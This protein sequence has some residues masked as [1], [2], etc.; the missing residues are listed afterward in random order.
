MQA[1]QYKKKNLA[2]GVQHRSHTD[3]TSNQTRL[4][5]KNLAKITCLLPSTGMEAFGGGGGGG[6]D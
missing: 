2:N 5:S 3:P 1:D 6:G 4:S